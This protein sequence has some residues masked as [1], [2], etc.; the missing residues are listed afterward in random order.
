V[1]RLGRV[2]YIV[3]ESSIQNGENLLAMVED[4]QKQKS[5]KLQATVEHHAS[6]TVSEAK[7]RND[8]FN[9]LIR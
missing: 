1:I 5:I 3:K 8:S 7:I 6:P 2:C 9:N 4:F